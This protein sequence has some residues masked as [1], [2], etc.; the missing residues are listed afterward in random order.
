[1]EV[2][3]APSEASK[4]L[5]APKGEK[6][7]DRP[8]NKEGLDPPALAPDS[9]VL[10]RDLSGTEESLLLEVPYK[11]LSLLLGMPVPGNCPVG[12]SHLGT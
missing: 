12:L 2:P 9:E 4:F 3:E 6:P 5:T 8:S 11:P 7:L 10:K 1:M